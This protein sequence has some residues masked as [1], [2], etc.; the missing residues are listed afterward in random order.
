MALARRGRL[1]VELSSLTSRRG[2]IWRHGLS[3]SGYEQQVG[4]AIHERRTC[5]VYHLKPG[6]FIRQMTIVVR[7]WQVPSWVGHESGVKQVETA[8]VLDVEVRREMPA[9]LLR[10]KKMEAECDLPAVIE[11]DFTLVPGVILLQSPDLRDRVR[12]RPWEGC[13]PDALW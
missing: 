2:H 10:R 12:R 4:G 3:T 11:F 1:I 7:G 13:Q 8:Q 6:E 9:Q 5:G